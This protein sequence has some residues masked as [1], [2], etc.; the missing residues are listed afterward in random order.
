MGEINKTYSVEFKQ[1]AVNMYLKQGMGYKSIAK[2]LG[3]THRSVQ[4]WVK[5][6]QEEGVKGL[7]EKRGKTTG[8][9][10]GRPRTREQSVEEELHRLRA[11]NE[12][13]KKLWALQRGQ[14]DDGNKHS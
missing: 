3:I 8:P 2:E 4:R 10:K 1:K 13:L 7:E 11:E 6:F 5:Y 9:L 14:T 12:Y